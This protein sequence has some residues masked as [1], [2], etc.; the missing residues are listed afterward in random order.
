MLLQR[1]G[2]RSW[3]RRRVCMRF[4]RLHPCR[5]C[6]RSIDRERGL[7]VLRALHTGIGITAGVYLAPISAMMFPQ[8]QVWIIPQY[9]GDYVVV[10]PSGIDLAK[11]IWLS[12]RAKYLASMNSL[13]SHLTTATHSTFSGPIQ[14][15]IPD[16]AQAYVRESLEKLNGLL[17]TMLNLSDCRTDHGRADFVAIL[18]LT[19]AVDRIAQ[20]ILAITTSGSG[21][22]RLT[23]SFAAI[24]LISSLSVAKL[25]I[26]IS[27]LPHKRAASNT[28]YDKHLNRLMRSMEALLSDTL[29]DVDGF[30]AIVDSGLRTWTCVAAR[31]LGS[32]ARQRVQDLHMAIRKT[33]FAG[34]SSKGRLK[35]RFRKVDDDSGRRGAWRTQ[36]ISKPDLT[37]QVVRQLRNT[38][39]GYNCM[40]SSS[41][42]CWPLP[43]ARSAIICH[44]ISNT[45]G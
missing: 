24:D 12:W 41:R 37:G 5:A 22:S 19:F 10:L 13:G 38:H 8:H 11:D 15:V 28:S 3:Q 33:V 43:T 29:L 45:R 2:G 42:A 35:I 18:K 9:P 25:A 6:V 44:R 31:N 17:D 7:P 36:T 39:H 23:D 27:Q 16:S 30:D 4:G 32:T 20:S 21:Y 26:R 34:T 14:A 40:M 1:G